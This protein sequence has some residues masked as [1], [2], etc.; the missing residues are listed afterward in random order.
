MYIN[1]LKG[2]G[3]EGGLFYTSKDSFNINFS[4]YNITLN[5]L[6]QLNKSETSI[7]YIDKNNFPSFDEYT[8]I[9]LYNIYLYILIKMN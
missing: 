9:I 4:G 2:N 3:E 8:I 1:N 6:Y 5:N 7:I